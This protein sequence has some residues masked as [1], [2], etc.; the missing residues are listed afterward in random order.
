MELD[1]TEFTARNDMCDYSASQAELGPNAGRITWG[2]A[3]T[4]AEE[5]RFLTT[6]D[7]IDHARD[8]FRGMGAWEEHEINA[9]S[10]RHVTAMVIQ[11]IA[12]RMREIEDNCMGDDGEIDWE[13]VERLSEAGSISGSI[14]TTNDKIYMYLGD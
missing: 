10:A 4:E 14:Y 13:E 5:T 9:W 11:E 7:E 12:C 6:P 8:Y 1:I 3:M 2:N